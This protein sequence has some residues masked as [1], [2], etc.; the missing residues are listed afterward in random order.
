MGKIAAEML[1][2]QYGK[3]VLGVNH[4]YGHIFSLLLERNVADLPFPW[5]ILTASGGHNEIYRID[6]E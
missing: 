6:Y 5:V 2:K 4:V 1:G 3:K